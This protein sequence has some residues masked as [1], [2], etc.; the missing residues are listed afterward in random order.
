MSVI[1]ILTIFKPS[2]S[3][4][5][6]RPAKP[7]ESSSL[8]ESATRSLVDNLLDTMRAEPGIGLA[9]TQIGYELRVAVVAQETDPDLSGDL[10]LINPEVTPIGS[11][12]TVMEEGCLSVPGVF[13]QVRRPKKIRLQAINY[14]GEPYTI[15]AQGLLARVIQHEFDHL[16]G[17]LFIDL[18]PK[19]TT[20]KNLL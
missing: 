10:V 19:F 5:L 7:V 4:R 11:A 6:R 3:V 18:H 1:P 20:G 16:R 17:I 8:T 9:A 12:T 15:D 13:G 14:Q 2:G